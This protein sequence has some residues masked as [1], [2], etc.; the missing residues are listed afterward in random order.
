MWLI[1]IFPTGLQ[2]LLNFKSTMWHHEK[3]SYAYWHCGHAIWTSMTSTGRRRWVT[4]RRGMEQS[5]PGHHHLSQPLRL[6]SF[7]GWHSEWHS[8]PVS[9]KKPFLSSQSLPLLTERGND[10]RAKDVKKRANRGIFE[11]SSLSIPVHLSK[12]EAVPICQAGWRVVRQGLKIECRES[13]AEK[14][15]R[16]APRGYKLAGA[17]RSR[18]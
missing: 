6:V 2:F 9:L 15:W 3:H 10:W 18:I 11:H 12:R 17:G 8:Q 14:I 16:A 4:P 7:T 5:W 1:S 13:G